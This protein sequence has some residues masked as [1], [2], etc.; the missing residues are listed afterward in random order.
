MK[1]GLNQIISNGKL[2]KKINGNIYVLKDIFKGKGTLTLN[3]S[4]IFD[5]RKFGANLSDATFYNEFVR[6]RETQVATLNFSYRFGSNQI[7][8]SRD[9]KTGLDSESKRIK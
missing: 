4:D 5:W 8:N 6:K 7:K 3:V 9:R 1:G 2:S